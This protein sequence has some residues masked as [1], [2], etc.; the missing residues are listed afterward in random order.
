MLDNTI[1]NPSVLSLFTGAGGMDL[2]FKAAGFH[3]LCA[4]EKEEWATTTLRKNHPELPVL[5]PPQHS[6]EIQNIGL[7]DLEKFCNIKPGDVDVILGG[8]PCQPFSQAATQ[9]FWKQDPRYKRRGFEDNIRGTLLFDFV[10]LVTEFLPKVFVLENVPGLMNIDEGTQLKIVLES[11]TKLGYNVSRPTVL[12]A[13]EYGVPQHR[14]RLII[15]GSRKVAKPSLPNPAYGP[16][17]NLFVFPYNT[18]AHALVGMSRSLPNHVT[19]NHA[20]ESIRRYQTLGIGKREKLGRVDRLD[21]FK[22]SKTVIAGGMHGGGRSHL[23]PFIA[24]T[25]SVRENARIQTF[26]DTFVFEGNISRQFTQ[27]G[28][29]VP[30]LLAEHLARHIKYL[31]FGETLTKPFH[32]GTYLSHSE[33][34]QTLVKRLLLESRQ[35]KAE[36]IYSDDIESDIVNQEKLETQL[37]ELDL[38]F[39][40]K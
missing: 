37:E 17:K 29:A 24:R 30:P 3:L 26:D 2:G 11:L 38:F 14:T 15:W 18:V 34:V 36:W 32:H 20:P 7:S 16:T 1:Y 40:N 28:N 35:E 6:G 12:D 19:R 21:P 8:P 4:I 13:A 33:D 27:V 10:R 9:R 31:E 23:H 5:G 39:V 22:P 25:L